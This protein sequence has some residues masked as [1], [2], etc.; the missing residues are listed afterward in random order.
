[1]KREI[2][3]RK[4]NFKEIFNI[5]HFPFFPLIKKFFKILLKHL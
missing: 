1:M 4:Q 3:S 5:K 2:L